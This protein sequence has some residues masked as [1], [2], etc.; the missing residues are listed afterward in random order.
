[1]SCCH[2]TLSMK[3]SGAPVALVEVHMNI[4][5]DCVIS[6]HVICSDPGPCFSWLV[7]VLSQVCVPSSHI[8]LLIARFASHSGAHARSPVFIS[9][10]LFSV[11]RMFKTGL[12]TRRIFSFLRPSSSRWRTTLSLSNQ[13]HAF[14]LLVRVQ[15]SCAIC[16]CFPRIRLKIACTTFQTSEWFSSI[17]LLL[18]ASLQ[19]KRQ[20]YWIIE[21]VILDEELTQ[22][23]RTLPPQVDV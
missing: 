17:V 1:M 9:K 13:V 11:W 19:M 3:D 15:L 2:C 14:F 4:V 20:R 8:L 5:L 16:F 23:R 12:N 10:L 18:V 21:F 6:G 7:P 22:P